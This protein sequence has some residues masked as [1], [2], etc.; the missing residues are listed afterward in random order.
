MSEALT[1]EHFEDWR[2]R[3]FEPHTLAEETYMRKVDS[4]EAQMSMWLK[5]VSVA[6]LMGG[7]VISV[8]M[9]ILLEKNSQVAA[10]QSAIIAISKEQT[11]V[12]AIVDFHTIELQRQS[13]RDTQIMQSLIDAMKSI[14]E[15]DR[16]K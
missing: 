3:E 2:A 4:I 12:D 6:L 8:F 16:H 14:Q 9:W 10:M 7:C 1:R 11:K 15:K 5:V 13:N